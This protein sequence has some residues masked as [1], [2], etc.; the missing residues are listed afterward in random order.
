MR[1]VILK[2]LWII[3][4]AIVLVRVRPTKARDMIIWKTSHTGV[5]WNSIKC[6]CWFLFFVRG[7]PLYSAIRTGGAWPTP[8]Y[9]RLT[10][11][12]KHTLTSRSIFSRHF[13]FSPPS[14]TS[15]SL[16][17]SLVVR[18][19]LTPSCDPSTVQV[20]PSSPSTPPPDK[21]PLDINAYCVRPYVVYTRGLCSPA[22]FFFSTA[23]FRRFDTVV[24]PFDYYYFRIRTEWQITRH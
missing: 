15:L 6:G 2:L 19:A 24:G 13:R 21:T 7:K 22:T 12:S 8:K 18:S 14:E 17:L 20:P 9:T 11:S 3:I 5:T 16:S 1:M 23:V 4:G 10:T